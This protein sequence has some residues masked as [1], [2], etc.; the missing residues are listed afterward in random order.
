[1]SRELSL[2]AAT[3]SDVPGIQELIRA[4]VRGLSVGYYDPLQIETAI[5]QVFGVDS[6][7]IDDG[8]YYVIEEIGAAS[9]R[10]VAAGGWSKRRTLYGGD[11]MK[12]EADPLLDPATEPARIRAFFVHPEMARRGLARM[13]FAECERAARS[14]GFREFVLAAT[15]PGQPLYRSLGFVDVE[16]VDQ[17]MS[18]G[19]VLPL[20]KMRRPID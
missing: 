4:S 20:V 6:Q 13:L 12:E 17:P 8:S 18:D 7:L 10:P 2:R 16:S 11:Q 19:L 14:A 5:A 3:H 15:L 9:S 1:M